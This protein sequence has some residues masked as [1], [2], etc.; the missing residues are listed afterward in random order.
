MAEATH[1]QDLLRA[2]KLPE[3]LKALENAV[4]KDPADAGLRVFLFQLLAVVGQWDRALTQ[5]K[6]AGGSPSASSSNAV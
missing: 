1:A 3:A 4:R 2:G 5:V 6:L